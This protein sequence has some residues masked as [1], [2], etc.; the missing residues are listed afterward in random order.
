MEDPNI[1][2]IFNERFD[3]LKCFVETYERTPSRTAKNA[4]EKKLGVYFADFRKYKKSSKG[5][6]PYYIQK[7]ESLGTVW[8]WTYDNV[9]YDNLE[10]LKKWISQNGRLPVYEKNKPDPERRLGLYCNKQR[11]AYV[12]GKLKDHDKISSLEQVSGWTWTTYDFDENFERLKKFVEDNGR[13]PNNDG[14]LSEKKI[15]KWC[16]TQKNKS[17]KLTAEQV[18]KLQSINGWEWKNVGNVFSK[19]Y[20]GLRKWMKTHD[21]TYPKLDTDN[22]WEKELAEFVEFSKTLRQKYLDEDYDK[23]KLFECLPNW[24]W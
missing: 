10:D 20:N 19:K 22:M 13:L 17:E 5:L 8:R 1:Y 16:L 6:H 12:N 21:F 11:E 4:D 9:F 18:T 24:E 3:K 14:D 23:I 7:L 2:K 15:A